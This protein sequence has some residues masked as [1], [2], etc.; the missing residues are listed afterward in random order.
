MTTLL[1]PFFGAVS[2]LGELSLFLGRL[3]QGARRLPKRFDLFINQCEFIG[4]SSFGILSV[5]AVFMGAV[6]GYQLYTSFALFGAQAMVGGTIGVSLFREMAP[7]MG[8]IM[9]T[10]RAGAAI[11]AEVASMRVTEQIDALDVMG[12]D[13]F[14]YLVAPRVAAGMAM[15]PLLSVVFG[16][17]ATLAGCLIA[18]SV[19][20]LSMPVFWKTFRAWVD[21]VDFVHCVIKGATFG[22]A[23]TTIGCF[24][25]FRATGGARAVGLST[26]STVVATCLT[27]LLLDYFWTMVLPVRAPK[28]FFH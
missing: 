25:G 23:L 11:G 9:V 13:P 3:L 22:F 17:I 8:A 27:I 14:E 26:R 28:L 15:M 10:G 6:L 18:T 1:S 24:Y 20:G 7:V 12:V 21:W 16:A 19:L 5:A 4:V 2:W